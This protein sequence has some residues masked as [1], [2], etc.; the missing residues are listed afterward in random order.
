M[1]WLLLSIIT[2]TALLLILKSF[3]KFEVN[4]LQG[5]VVNY[6][7]AGT[8]G[9]LLNGIPLPVSAIPHQP[10]SWVPPVLGGLFI[11]IFL[12]L[13]K[14]A[15]TIGVSVATVANKMSLVI[16]VLAAVLFYHDSVSF[17]KITGLVIAIISVYLTSLPSKKD[18]PEIKRAGLK[19]FW[20]PAVIFIGSGV[21]DSLVNHAKIR[22]VP[23]NHLTIFL[24]LCF[25]CAGTIGITVILFRRIRF[26]EKFQSKSIPA[27]IILG[28]PNYF[29]IYGITRALGCNLMETSELIPVNNMGIVALSAVSALVI[30]REKFSPVNWLGILLALGA[31]ALIAFGK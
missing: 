11:S 1:Y 3:R 13:A 17:I 15:Q 12:L 6:F 5:I 10:W 25:F 20:M 27:G 19:Y 4:T 21:L 26:G 28:I 18:P 2:N 16:P 22:L 7:T 14:T 9:L 8:T 24:S 31:I 29:S 23:D 30:F